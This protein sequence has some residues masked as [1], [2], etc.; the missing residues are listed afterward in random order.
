MLSVKSNLRDGSNLRD[1]G[2][3][4]GPVPL[5]V[6]AAIAMKYVA[7]AVRLVSSK[8]GDAAFTETLLK[9]VLLE[10]PRTTTWYDRITPL[11]DESG[12]SFHFKYTELELRRRGSI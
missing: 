9:T 11:C 1:N 5:F 3:E 7:P 10:P 4:K 8:E 2:F 12:G 6:A